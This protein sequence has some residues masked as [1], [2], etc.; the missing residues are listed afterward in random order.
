MPVL[1]SHRIRLDF[2]TV[3]GFA[4]MLWVALTAV[5]ATSD[6]EAPWQNAYGY[7]TSCTNY[8]TI[9]PVGVLFRGKRASAVNSRDEIKFHS[10]WNYDVHKEQHL[11][12]KNKFGT[13]ECREADRSVA[14]KPDFP[15]SGRYHTR[16]WFVPHTNGSNDLW[17]VGTPHHEDL[18]LCGHAVDENGSE[19]SGFDR[20]RHSL[21]IWFQTS[22]HTVKTGE[23]WGNTETAKQC[24]GGYAGSDG[25]GITVYLNSLMRP[26]AKGAHI[27]STG[28]GTLK[29]TLTTEEQTTE[30][31][32]AY[33]PNPSQ[34]ESGYPYETAVESISGPAEI[35]VDKAV[36]SLNLNATYYARMFARNQD[37]EVEE[38]NEISFTRQEGADGDYAPGPQVIV[39]NSGT[40]HIFYR[41]TKGDLGHR[42]L[43]RGSKTW[44]Q[45]TQQASIAA[46]SVPHAILDGADT[47][48]VFYRETSGKLG[49]RWLVAGSETWGQASESLPVPMSGDPRVLL[50]TGDTLHVFYRDTNGD[51]SHR[52]LAAGAG[53]WGQ[54]TQQASIAANSAP[55]VLLDG[56]DTLHVFF[57]EPSGKL[58][59]R[60]LP[61][62]TETWGQASEAAS[63]SGDPRVIRDTADT[64]H[65]FYREP[66]GKLGHRWLAAGA[67]S[68]GQETQQA[69]IASNSVPQAIL[70]GAHTLHVFFRDTSGKLGYRW[71][72]AGSEHWGA[73][74]KPASMTNDPRVLLDGANTLHVFFRELSGNLGHR[75]LAAGSGWGQETQQTN[76]AST[77]VPVP[78]SGDSGINVFYRDTDG[79]LGDNWLAAGSESW[80]HAHETLPVSMSSGLARAEDRDASPGPHTIV[81]TADTLHA[82]YREPSGKLGHRWLAAGS[83]SWGQAS[84]AASIA[85]SSVPS[86]ILDGADTLHVFFREPSGK[87]GHRWLPAGS[88]TWGQASEAASMTGDPRPLTDGADTLHVFYR[89]PSGKLGHRWLPAGSETWG[90]A[91]EAASMTG[92]PRPLTDG[93]DTLHVFYR[94]PSGKLGHRWLPA[95]S[96]TW[97]QASEAA[98]MS[99]DPRP[100][101]DGADT[102]HVFYREPSGK[103]GHRWLPAGSETWGQ[104]SESASMTGDP[105][106]LTDG[107]DTLHVFYREPS[108]KLGHRW[109][110]AGS[111]SW[112][113]A[114]ESASMTGDPRPLTD[115]ADTLHVFYR[116]PSGK[117]GHRWLPA[118]SETW[119][120]A[121]ESASMTGDPRPLTDG[122]D[123][124]HVFYRE[125]SGKLGHRWLPAGSESWGQ[126][127]E[128]AS[129]AAR[130]PAVATGAATE[131]GSDEATVEGTV[132]PEGSSTSYHFEYGATTSYGSKQPAAAKEIGYG[133]SSVSVSEALSGLEP[134]TTYHYRLVAESPEGTTEGEDETF[135]TEA[136][137]S[138]GI[139]EQLASMPVTTAF[140]GSSGSEAAF[141][142]D[143][144]KLGWAVG[145][146]SDRTN[147]WGPVTAF[148]TGPDGI[149]HETELSGGGPLAVAATLNVAPGLTSRYFSL[150]LDM[151]SPGGSKNGYELRLTDT[152]STYEV[153]LSK[154]AGGSETVL[155]S[156]TGY[157]FSLDD[158]LALV[159]EGSTVSAWADTGSGYEEHWSASDS[160]FGSGYPGLE[161]GGNYTRLQDFRAGAL[162]G[163]AEQLTEMPVTTAFDGSSGSEAAFDED[164]SKLGW[165]VGKGSD[166]TNGWGPVTAFN[167]GP[168]GIYHEAELSGGSPLAATVTLSHWPGLESRYFALWLDMSSPAGAKNGYELRLTYKSANTYDVKLS[169][170]VSG[171]E[172]VL[173]SQSG[174]SFAV[175]DSLALVDE[176]GTVSAWTD[177]GSGYEEQWSASDNAFGSGYPGLESGGNYTRLQDFRAGGL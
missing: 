78:V 168:D 41:D 58:G 146:G 139:A 108:G 88:E 161:S 129:I 106:P 132:N 43:A 153:T 151:S 92:D 137:G 20:G 22:R 123:T 61:A 94:E 95:G 131:V 64:L 112:G 155:D 89:E 70:D 60:W 97:G 11:Y 7:S 8:N 23:K 98:S 166:R 99:G 37:G 144:S 18:E 14:N 101:T 13:F 124:L 76:I 21:R 158:S 49:H 141:D 100:L 122:A 82:F 39:D 162:A 48:H 38:G 93:A 107:A 86:T 169:K 120:Q 69:S 9:D 26:H 174:Y 81:D 51:L 160:A 118:G 91:S 90:Q 54:E 109:L 68:W 56:A 42:W 156:E 111:E 119:G 55:H 77:A 154:W 149:Y 133:A 75:W 71:L 47:L 165:A 79:K 66:S 171:S 163:I 62:G 67:G 113:Q 103:L 5:P 172:T 116:E 33:G 164:F 27:S 53:S 59:H 80:G 145:K 50:D 25:Y 16:L 40:A 104:A 148:N 28:K 1:R 52:W 6:A 35:D 10:D 4:A 2:L 36:S 115:G 147:G 105:R 65:V 110:P 136:S 74:T 167:T 84:E 121:S 57:R 126:A 150:W 31:W 173:D 117:L 96:E 152:G 87:L 134:G 142:E 19:G 32:F 177:T 29:G 159:D 85:E 176:G 46:D 138:S 130:P 73:D 72:A 15:P 12:V 3:I 140:D 63:M 128:A 34:G 175:G 114:S 44:G 170:W 17:T 24:D 102:L 45:E 157:S 127:S 83:E 30:W 125:P 143:F 135:E